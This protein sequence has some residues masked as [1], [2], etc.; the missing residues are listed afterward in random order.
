DVSG[1]FSNL[2]HMQKV[3]E[4]LRRSHVPLFQP[5]PWSW[6]PSPPGHSLDAQA[7]ATEIDTQTRFHFSRI[8]FEDIVCASL[9]YEA[10]SVEWFLL[11]HNCFYIHLLEHLQA[12]PEEIP[13]YTDVE[14][15]LQPRN[16]F[17]YRA[18]VQCLAFVQQQATR[19]QPQSHVPCFEFAAGP[20]QRLFEDRPP[21]LST[22]L[23]I[24]SVLGA[25]FEKQYIHTAVLNWQTPFDTKRSFLED[26]L[27]ST[28]P[29]DLA[30]TLA[31]TDEMN[32][33]ALSGQSIAVDNVEVKNLVDNWHSL[34]SSVWECCSSLPNMMIPYLRECAQV[35]FNQRSYHSL[36][37]ILHGLH[38]WEISTAQPQGSNSPG[39]GMIVLKPIL[40]PKITS[41]IASTNDYAAYHQRYRKYPGIPFLLPHIRGRRQHDEITVPPF[42]P[43]LQRHPCSKEDERRTT[44]TP[45]GEERN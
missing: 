44:Y 5:I 39:G 27:T 13:L 16:P 38:R 10:I 7:I 31:S 32:F 41:L 21:G 20:I 18:L 19:N 37:A 11:Q 45:S 22:I 30:D 40:P 42:F 17:A 26:C 25:R 3:E 35:L 24:L 34:S 36:T 4:V 9:G 8:A 28:S 23:K 12:Y 1:D 43:C 14:T 29:T 2:S 15:H 33:S 6:F